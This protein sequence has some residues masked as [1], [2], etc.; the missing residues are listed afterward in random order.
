[1]V[2]CLSSEFHS[3]TITNILITLPCSDKSAGC[4][5]A[6][7]RPLHSVLS[8]VLH[9]QS[10][11][12][13]YSLHGN[14]FPGLLLT[15]CHAQHTP[16]PAEYVTPVS[17][18]ILGP[19]VGLP[20]RPPVAPSAWEAGAGPVPPRVLSA[21]YSASLQG[22]DFQTH[23]K[24]TNGFRWLP[25]RRSKLSSGAHSVLSIV[26]EIYLPFEMNSVTSTFLVLILTLLGTTKGIG[27]SCHQ[28]LN[29]EHT[30]YTWERMGK[31]TF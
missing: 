2:S 3:G 4:D 19:S 12:R 25:G 9:C 15:T 21:E 17:H 13:C 5:P 18:C 10:T 11:P 6:L 26:H 16:Q 22:S 1:M 30:S 14:P 27:L 23:A 24:G 20:T 29:Q 28:R 8:N 7:P 31:E